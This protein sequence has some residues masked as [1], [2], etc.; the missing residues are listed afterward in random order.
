MPEHIGRQVVNGVPRRRQQFDNARLPGYRR[1]R[2]QEG[3]ASYG[4]RQANP[5]PGLA[6]S[7]YWVNGGWL[8]TV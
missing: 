7:N 4:H 2:S 3:E 8:D 6:N 5:G 1:H